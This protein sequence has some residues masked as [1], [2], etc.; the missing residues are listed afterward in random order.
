MRRV[1]FVGPLPPPLNG[2]SN[3]CSMML[4]R[5]NARMAVEVF[6]RAPDQ[7]RSSLGQV[8]Q[9]IYPAKY[10]LSSLKRADAALYLALSG[11][12]GQAIDL[13][14]LLIGRVLR[15][16]VFVHHH[17]F[18]Y[19]NSPSWLSRCFFALARKETHIVLSPNMGR[20]LASAY[21]LD[22]S[23]IRVVSN[24]AFYEPE[25]LTPSGSSHS[26]P[27]KLG[28]LSNIT[29]EKGILEFFAVLKELRRRGLKYEAE[30]AGPL[31][32]EARAAFEEQLKSARDVTYLGPL[33]GEAKE[34]FYRRIDVFLFPTK[35]ANEA[36]PLVVHE[37]MRRGVYVIACD[38]G[39]IGEMLD[40]GSGAAFDTDQFVALAS[41]RIEQLSAD[42]DRLR[43]C[44]L[45]AARQAE[46]IRISSATE[47]ESLMDS[48][49]KETY[50][51]Q[52]V[53]A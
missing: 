33:Y 24:A 27:L 10:L 32:P 42:R 1:A 50:K 53:N 6:D 11:G 40:N 46:R 35:Y 5:L 47:L 23:V 19:V 21:G 36:E 45:M 41:C 28:F 37:A 2:F 25:A 30:I 39:A 4:V 51:Q 44:Q 3:V 34:N 7:K 8:R 29:F 26:L 38:R 15:R 49:E 31:A 20:R 16:P 43:A 14:Y 22:A 12:R 48:M 9:L 17:S 52:G 18:A 13:L